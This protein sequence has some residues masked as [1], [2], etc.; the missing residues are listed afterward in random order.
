MF[1]SHVSW[2]KGTAGNGRIHNQTLP[3]HPHSM[4]PAFLI[5]RKLNFQGKE[6]EQL[7]PYYPGNSFQLGEENRKKEKALP[8]NR[9][10]ILARPSTTGKRGTGAIVKAILHQFIETAKTEADSEYQRT[11]FLFHFPTEVTKCSVRCRWENRE[12]QL[13]SI[14]TEKHSRVN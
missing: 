3:C 1:P 5:E 4:S 7:S 11:P 12:K 13:L 14:D 6:Q 2:E 10:G 9:A 8:G